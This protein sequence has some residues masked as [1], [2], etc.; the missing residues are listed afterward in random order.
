MRA[1]SSKNIKKSWFVRN[2]SWGEWKKALGN[3]W[4]IT[5][6]IFALFSSF[7]CYFIR[8]DSENQLAHE[9]YLN[10]LFRNN[11][12]LYIYLNISEMDRFFL[13][14]ENA[15]LRQELKRAGG[16]RKNF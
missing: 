14:Q 9:Y 12:N 13:A 10:R 7:L 11:E 5:A 1:K 3:F 2:L 4:L 8:V 16:E 15:R 6:L